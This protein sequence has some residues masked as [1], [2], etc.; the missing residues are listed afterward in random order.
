[1]RPI[2]TPSAP[3]GDRGVQADRNRGRNRRPPQGPKPRPR[4]CQFNTRRTRQNQ[5][6]RLTRRPKRTAAPTDTPTWRASPG[7]RLDAIEAHAEA[8]GQGRRLPR[9]APLSQT[10]PAL[11]AKA[12]AYDRALGPRAEARAHPDPADTAHLPYLDEAQFT[13]DIRAGRHRDEPGKS[14]IAEKLARSGL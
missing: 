13:E 8:T 3:H 10:V 1:M 11:R 5:R 12:K 14:A 4:V 6:N 2:K 9:E 7:A